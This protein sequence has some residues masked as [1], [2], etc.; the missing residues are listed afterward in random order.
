MSGIVIGLGQLECRPLDRDANLVLAVAALEEAA[1]AGAKVVVLPELMTSGYVLD[2]TLLWPLAESVAEGGQAL[3]V[4]SDAA[5]RLN[6]TIVAGFPE[7]DGDR[8]FNAAAVFGPDGELVGTYR[9]LHLFAGEADVFD[10]GDRGLPVFE[11]DGLRIGVLICFDLR[12]PEALRIL[13]VQRADLVTVPT[14]WVGG[15]DR[16]TGQAE[17]GQVRTVRVLANLNAVPVAC[18]SQVG[19]SGPFAFLGS[20]VLVDPFGADVEPVASTVKAM[21][22]LGSLDRDLLRLARDRGEGLSP[23]TQRRTDI[24]EHLLGYRPPVAA[25]HQNLEVDPWSTS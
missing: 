5:A 14:A 2:R 20:S 12:F 1:A 9:K 10:P 24:Y 4:L 15:F 13:S 19:S 21:T 11:V 25:G 7:R 3:T 6:V 16:D 8:L 23:L 17:I 22:V 18:A